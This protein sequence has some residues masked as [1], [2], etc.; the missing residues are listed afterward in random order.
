MREREEWQRERGDRGKLERKRGGGGEG[1]VSQR[2]RV[3]G[4]VLT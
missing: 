2:K 3:V 4:V 1:R